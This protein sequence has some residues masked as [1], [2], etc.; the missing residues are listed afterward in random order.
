MKI[1]FLLPV[2]LAATCSSLSVPF[3]DSSGGGYAFPVFAAGRPATQS[4]PYGIAGIDRRKIVASKLQL[5]VAEGP[6][7]SGIGARPRSRRMVVHAPRRSSTLEEAASLHVLGQVAV[8]SGLRAK[9]GLAAMDRVGLD[10]SA[11][12]RTIGPGS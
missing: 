8:P 3:H 1:A 11:P 7:P 10:G 12:S 6:E 5:H 2:L 4:L 9:T